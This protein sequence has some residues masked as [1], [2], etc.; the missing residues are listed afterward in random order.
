MLIK[1]VKKQKICANVSNLAQSLYQHLFKPVL[2]NVA[3]SDK[4]VQDFMSKIP[5]SYVKPLITLYWNVIEPIY[6]YDWN[7]Y[8]ARTVAVLF[9]AIILARYSVAF[10]YLVKLNNMRWTIYTPDYIDPLVKD[11]I[12]DYTRD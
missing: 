8:K 7:Y 9:E 4:M 10:E 1:N 5:L 6:I 11:Y 12:L 2:D 3:A